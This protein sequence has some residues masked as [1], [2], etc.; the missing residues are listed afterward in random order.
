MNKFQEQPEQP[1]QQEQQQP[2]RE[3]EII[4]CQGYKTY[5]GY[6]YVNTFPDEWILNEKKHTG[7]ECMNCYNIDCEAG[8]ADGYGM[9]R[10][11][12]I[13]Y[14]ANCAHYDYEFTRG[15]GFK[16]QAVENIPFEE[17]E[18]GDKV[19]AA[20]YTYLAGIDYENLGDINMNPQD[21]MKNKI[22]LCQKNE[23]LAYLDYYENY[24]SGYSSY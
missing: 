24:D 20:S 11:I 18:Y 3:P 2:E 8:I 1:Q 19:L 16:G 9:W 14:C 13:G 6:K 12:F 5:C 23:L 21:T 4:Y 22:R 17:D 15:Y 10:G 7:R